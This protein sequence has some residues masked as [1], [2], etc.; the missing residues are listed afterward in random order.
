[1]LHPQ[2]EGLLHDFGTVI[3]ELIRQLGGASAELRTEGTSYKAEWNGRAYLW[4][5]FRGDRAKRY[6]PNSVLLRTYWD[7]AFEGWTERTFDLPGNTPSAS[8][9]ARPEVAEEVES[10]ERFIRLALANVQR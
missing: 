7:T 6:K 2:T 1:M 9:S 5:T 4:V 3:F 8:Y 10:A